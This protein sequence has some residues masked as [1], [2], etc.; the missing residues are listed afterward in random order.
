MDTYRPKS[1]FGDG[2]F[3]AGYWGGFWQGGFNCRSVEHGGF[4]TQVFVSK[5]SGQPGLIVVLPPQTNLTRILAIQPAVA[6]RDDAIQVLQANP[7]E[8]PNFIL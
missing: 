5:P 4:G 2:D 7:N 8:K 1:N 6:S 3:G